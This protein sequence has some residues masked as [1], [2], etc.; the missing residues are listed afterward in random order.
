MALLERFTP[1]DLPIELPREIG[2]RWLTVVTVCDRCQ[3]RR[4]DVFVLGT[5]DCTACQRC[6]LI[7]ELG[8]S[9]Q[10]EPFDR[11]ELN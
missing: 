11:P 7:E 6:G 3:V 10:T 9:I 1:A 2:L 5:L 8:F 4:A